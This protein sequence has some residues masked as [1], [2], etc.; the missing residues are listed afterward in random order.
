MSACD[1]YSC[2]EFGHKYMKIYYIVELPEWLEGIKHKLGAL[3]SL[4]V[5]LF[6]TLCAMKQQ[7]LYLDALLSEYHHTF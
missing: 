7:Y 5:L 2:K 6:N 1:P 3:C 4:C